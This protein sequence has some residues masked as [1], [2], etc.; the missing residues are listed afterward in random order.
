MMLL[1]M[2]WAL[3]PARTQAGSVKVALFHTDL[4]RATPAK[5]LRDL[6]DETPD[7]IQLAVDRIVAADADILIVGDIDDDRDHLAA[8]AFRQRIATA[9]RAYPHMAV[10]R[11]NGGRLLASHRTAGYGDFHGDGAV[12]VLSRYE[13]TQV[14]DLQDWTCAQVQCHFDTDPSM[15]LSS[16]LMGM[17][18]I[19]GPTGP[20]WIGITHA[21]PPV[22]D[23]PEDR[24]GWRNFDQLMFWRDVLDRRYDLPRPDVIALLANI[25]P[26][27]GEGTK[28]GIQTV[29]TDP[30]LRDSAPQGCHY[31]L[32]CSSVTAYW[33]V[34]GPGAMRTYYLLPAREWA[35]VQ[36]GLSWGTPSPDESRHALVWMQLEEEAH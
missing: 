9:G 32:G 20:M 33:P 5:L 34:P 18:G 27:V 26:A 15:V 7:D 13:I 21:T 12:V 1:V 28:E 36:S 30:R 3:L 22:F 31:L 10:L 17:A 24:N 35:I 25:D 14:H 6:L 19:M 29:I 8:D 4:S 11:S 2:S 23:G 16:R